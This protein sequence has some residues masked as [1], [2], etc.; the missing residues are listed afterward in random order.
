MY[1]DENMQTEGISINDTSYSTDES[2]IDGFPPETDEIP[3]MLDA[4]VVIGNDPEAEVNCVV[5]NEQD[6]ADADY[7]CENDLD[8]EILFAEENG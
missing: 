7:I 6:C 4:R 8:G 2:V 5:G 1:Y 3:A